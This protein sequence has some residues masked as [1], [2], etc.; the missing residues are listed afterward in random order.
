MKLRGSKLNAD[1]KHHFLAQY[2]IRGRGT[3]AGGLRCRVHGVILRLLTSQCKNKLL[4]T[5][6]KVRKHELRQLLQ[7][8]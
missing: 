8:D 1:K 2:V 7:F 6:D 4:S 5:Q 3:E